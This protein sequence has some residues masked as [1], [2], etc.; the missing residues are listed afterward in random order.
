MST[1]LPA[2]MA[3]TAPLAGLT[4]PVPI[5]KRDNHYTLVGLPGFARD[6][7]SQLCLFVSLSLSMSLYLSPLPFYL[8]LLS[9]CL[10]M[11]IYL[12]PLPFYISL[13]SLPSVS[14]FYLSISPFYLSISPFYLSISL[15]LYLSPLSQC[16]QLKRM[17]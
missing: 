2:I 14:P 7:Y 8:S 1:T 9:F 12:S 16:Y 10:S 5:L 15:S 13:L 17:M 6:L 3:V 11:S 4:V